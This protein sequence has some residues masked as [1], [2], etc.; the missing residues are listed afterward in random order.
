MPNA[1]V[2]EINRVNLTSTVLTLKSI[3]ISDIFS[4]DFLDKP[5]AQS[6]EAALV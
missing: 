1:T 5:E 4:F 6:I 3:G 2:P